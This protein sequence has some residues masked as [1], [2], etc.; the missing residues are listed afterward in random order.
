MIGNENS[1]DLQ[2]K[3]QQI[4]RSNHC[5]WLIQNC[6]MHYLQ[7]HEMLRLFKSSFLQTRFAAFSGS[8]PENQAELLKNF[9]IRG[10][11]H[12]KLISS[13]D[14]NLDEQGL[15]LFDE[16]VTRYSQEILRTVHFGEYKQNWLSKKMLKKSLK[17]KLAS[18]IHAPA[19]SVSDDYGH[20]IEVTSDFDFIYSGAIMRFSQYARSESFHGSYLYSSVPYWVGFGGNDVFW[21]MVAG[22]DDLDVIVEQTKW[23]HDTFRGEFPWG[24]D[25][26]ALEQLTEGQG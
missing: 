10:A 8:A 21:D 2:E 9:L 25:F 11:L 6:E 17:S 20:T 7:Y 1:H 4:L 19:Y 22:S 5:L 15:A 18:L 16:R 23:L 3:A 13:V 26:N 24:I 12:A 14:F